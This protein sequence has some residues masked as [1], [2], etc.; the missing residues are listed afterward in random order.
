[1]AWNLPVRLGGE[2]PISPKSSFV[3]NLGFD[4]HGSGRDSVFM[5]VLSVGAAVGF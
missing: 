3:V 4:I 5:P 1:M 2:I